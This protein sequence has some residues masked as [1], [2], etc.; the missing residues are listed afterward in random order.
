MPLLFGL[1]MFGSALL[2]F[3]VQPLIGRLL[4]PLLGGSPLVWNTA[5]VFFQ[6]ILLLGYT[7][8]HRLGQWHSRSAVLLH[9]VVLTLP[10]L[11]L[12]FLVDGDRARTWLTQFGPMFGLL[13]LLLTIVGLPFFALATTAPLLQTWFS[14]SGHRR[15]SDPYFLYVASNAGSMIALVAY[16]FLIEPF[17]PLAMQ[18]ATWRVGYIAVV[19]AILLCGISIGRGTPPP[20]TEAAE[21]PPQP[22]TTARRLRW[23]G[24]S[25]LP[26]S[27]L[28]SVTSYLTT[29]LA[30]MPLL[31]L[32]P[33][34]LYLLTFMLAFSTS[35][36]IPTQTLGRVLMILVSAVALAMLLHASEPLFL[37]LACH[38]LMFFLAT[39]LAHCQLAADRPPAGDLTQ[40]YL[41]MSLGGVLGG[42]FNVWLAPL[43]FHRAGLIEYPLAIALVSLAR[44][45]EDD[46]RIRTTD[47]LLPMLLLLATLGWRALIQQNAWI[48]GSVADLS[49]Q[50]SLPAEN[51]RGGLTYGVSLLLAYMLVDRRLRFAIAIAGLILI[52]RMDDGPVGRTIL[53][54]R[55]HLGLVQVAIDPDEQ[56]IRMV[57]GN[58]IHGQQWRDRSDPRHGDPLTYYHRRG[59]MGEV[60]K[61][62]FDPDNRPIRIGAIGLGTGSLAAYAKPNQDWDFFELDPAVE[63][64]ARDDQYFT[65]LRDTKAKSMQVILGDAR[66]QLETIPDGSYNL[67]IVDA[68]SSD[69]IPIHLITAEALELYRRKLTPDGVLAIHLSNRYL[70]LSPIVAK[71]A[72][73]AEPAW[74]IMLAQDRGVDDEIQKAEG[75]FPSEW[76][77]LAPNAE[78]LA[79]WK[80]NRLFSPYRAP[81]GTPRW[82]D[83]YAALLAAILPVWGEPD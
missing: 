60:F 43:L 41:V 55:N 16:P 3:V 26:S 78:R 29:D 36:R 65:Y 31:W 51:L 76:V 74:T 15:A 44:S 62:G 42:I 1:T 46:P 24:L 2:L 9:A 61:Q 23:I 58:T 67:L 34:A 45:P 39:L 69:S 57:H 12:P 7:Y 13:A 5:L 17:L 83:D 66:L 71:L 73:S 48:A 19:V 47:W 37:V 79:P 21:T 18:S 59:P 52:S 28:V 27:L 72:E 11:I 68:F 64:L 33:L 77:L 4:L 38:L 25:A 49:K 40:F 56:F 8:A 54:E 20:V 10:L 80:R 35:I 50:L 53:L 30:P 63:K 75:R 32:L 82:T 70:K 22:I 6:G 81:A 14:R